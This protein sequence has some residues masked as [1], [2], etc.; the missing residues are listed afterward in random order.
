LTQWVVLIQ[1]SDTARFADT[2]AD[3]GFGPAWAPAGV[4]VAS[5]TPVRLLDGSSR[6]AR[7]FLGRPPRP[8]RFV[9]AGSAFVGSPLAGRTSAGNAITRK[10][11]TRKTITGNA[12]R[13]ALRDVVVTQLVVGPAWAVCGPPAAPWFG[14][15]GPGI[16]IGPVVVGPSRIGQVS[17]PRVVI[18]V[19]PLATRSVVNVVNGSAAAGFGRSRF[20]AP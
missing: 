1:P 11:I 18:R 15:V 5:G 17:R 20:A 7:R 4:V 12:A 3:L 8:A 19:V 16:V 9:D 2:G 14:L 6:A 13:T 10:T